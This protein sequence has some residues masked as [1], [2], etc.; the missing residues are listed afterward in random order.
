MKLLFASFFLILIY[1]SPAQA[2]SWEWA[3][4]MAGTNGDFA[5]S[6]AVDANGN[7]YVAGSFSSDTLRLDSLTYL[8]NSIL[9]PNSGWQ[10]YLAKYDALGNVVWARCSQSN[11]FSE[12][13]DVVVA[14]DG[15]VY[16]TGYFY[17]DTLQFDSVTIY[18]S[19]PGNFAD[20]FIVKY[21]NTGNVIWAKSAGGA[22]DDM[23]TS[24]AVSSDGNIFITG[25]FRSSTLTFDN[26]TN[27]TKVGPSNI[28]LA[29]YDN[30]GNLLWAKKGSGDCGSQTFLTI[31]KQYS[32]ALDASDNIYIAG[33][34]FSSSFDF[35]GTLISN[36]FSNN[37]SDNYMAKYD[38]Q[39]NVLWAKSQGLF[40]N[41]K[42]ADIAVEASGAY[43]ILAGGGLLTKYD[44]SGNLIST[45]LLSYAADGI[46][47]DLSGN[48]FT[49]SNRFSK[50]DSLGNE[51]ILDSL[52]STNAGSIDIATDNNGNVFSAGN[53]NSPTYIGNYYFVPIGAV[54]IYV[55]K[56]SSILSVIEKPAEQAI[57]RI[58]PNPSSGEITISSEEIL[59]NI[60][61][62]NLLGQIMYQSRPNEMNIS[63][64]LKQAG[65]YFVSATS[66]GKTS[67]MKL[68]IL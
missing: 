24:I 13:L 57:L 12:G 23:A 59:S 17:S 4:S 65:I 54:N 62:T 40:G 16:V 1:L 55:A 3:K 9:F 11:Y 56:L 28:F 37:T 52:V 10:T 5:N 63:M 45:L 44:V 64:Q 34:F 42:F 58:Y 60:T 53:F 22:I 19:N 61:V 7:S 50:Y 30:L 46:C 39:G 68:I 31:S 35:D 48:L 32:L 47:V 25:C 15:S 43:H 26:G 20:I 29:K 38:S 36:S 27:L 66:G 21:N 49:G 33:C 2:S 18:N 51:T 14:A 6:I 41:N 67:T 8:V